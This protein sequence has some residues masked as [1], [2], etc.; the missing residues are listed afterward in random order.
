MGCE[1]DI[2]H[3]RPLRVVDLR[4]LAGEPLEVAG[5]RVL[6]RHDRFVQPPQHQH[7]E[8]VDQQN[9]FD[10]VEPLVLKPNQHAG[11][12]PPQR[13]TVAQL[14]LALNRRLLAGVE[15]EGDQLLNVLAIG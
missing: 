11:L 13:D 12:D 14:H 1:D 10:G 7:R 3:D 2:E 4:D 15:E 6:L 5:Q 8:R 9:P